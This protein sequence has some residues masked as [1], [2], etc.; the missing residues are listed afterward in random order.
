MLSDRQ[1]IKLI[2]EIDLDSKVDFIMAVSAYLEKL[3]SRE[4]LIKIIRSMGLAK[5][6]IPL[7]ADYVLLAAI[8]ALRKVLSNPRSLIYIDKLI[9]EADSEP[10]MAFYTELDQKY[11]LNLEHK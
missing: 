6:L 7:P 3:I 11:N 10:D 9:T 8:V 1:E 2:L 5:V 4:V